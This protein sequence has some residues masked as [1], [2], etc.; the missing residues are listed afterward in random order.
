[1]IGVRKRSMKLG[2][3]ATA[4]RGRLAGFGRFER[5]R[6]VGIG[7]GVPAESADA[8]DELVARGSSGLAG[9]VESGGGVE[10]GRVCELGGVVLGRGVTGRR[11]RLATAWKSP[12]GPQGALCA[13]SVA[14][15]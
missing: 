14:K 4:R 10:L 8:A 12:V 1:M 6:E 13:R 15:A 2:W 5:G 3:V 9:V 7:G 11:E